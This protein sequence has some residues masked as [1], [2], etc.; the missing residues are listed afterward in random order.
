MRAVL[1]LMSFAAIVWSS[2]AGAAQQNFPLQRGV[3]SFTTPAGN[4]GCTYIPAGGTDVYAP[5]DG[6]PELICDR[7]EP[8]YLRFFLYKSGKAKLF[9]YVGDASCCSTENV[10]VYGDSWKK[11]AFTCTSKRSGLTCLRGGHGFFISRTSTKVY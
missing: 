10:L 8:S 3:I 2:A 1:L 11:G 7:V 9:R 4:I 5:K 6:G